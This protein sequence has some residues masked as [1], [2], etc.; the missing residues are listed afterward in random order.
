MVDSLKSNKFFAPQ[1]S[2][3][4][5]RRLDAERGEM[6][7]LL[8][9]RGITDEHL[10]QV[11]MTVDR[12]EFVEDAFLN[13]AYEDSALPIGNSQ[14]ISQ[15]YTVAFMTQALEIQDGDKVLEIGTGS[16]YQ[17]A[18]LAEMGARVF[19][20]ERHMNLLTEARKSFDK[21]EYTIASKCGD[22]TIGWKEFAPFKGILVTAGAPEVPQPLLDQLADGGT[23]VIPIGNLDVQSLHVITR[24]NGQFESHVVP[25]FK[26][27]PLI[28]KLGWK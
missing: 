6:I 27:V 3:K 23:L 10:L 24:R 7:D 22:G 13:R 21:M 5:V 14:T 8:R 1:S 25:S 17:A 12:R 19:T 11:M 18:I 26:F 16:G 28:G 9:Q 2:G 15:P 20:I 4:P